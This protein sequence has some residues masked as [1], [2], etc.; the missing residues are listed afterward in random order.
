VVPEIQL[1]M[2]VERDAAL[3]RRPTQ[4]DRGDCA[5]F[6]LIRPA[7]HVKRLKHSISRFAVSN[8]PMKVQKQGALQCNCAC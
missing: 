8:Q 2:R 5:L 7:A 1:M 3:Q 4:E 6:E